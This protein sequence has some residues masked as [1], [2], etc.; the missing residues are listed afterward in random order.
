MQRGWLLL[1]I[2]VVASCRRSEDS[3]PALLSRGQEYANTGRTAEA[4][5]SFSRVLRQDPSNTIALRSRGAL[6]GD[7]GKYEEAFADLQLAIPDP[8]ALY[9]RAYIY[10]VMKRHEE[11]IADSQRLLTLDPK[12]ELAAQAHGIIAASYSSL[13][14]FTNAAV[15]Y[16]RVSELEPENA[17]AYIN[18]GGMLVELGQYQEA[19]KAFSKAILLKPKDYTGWALRFN[20]RR[21][22]GDL[23]GAE[24]DRQMAQT[25]NPEWGAR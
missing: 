21:L 20:A 4:I 23:R 17:M 22:G 8:V 11:A 9:N 7:L 15:H 18:F 10:H 14:D 25:L 5:D 16:R 24:A 3:T 6:Y 12:T 19:D 2:M 13:S 1:L